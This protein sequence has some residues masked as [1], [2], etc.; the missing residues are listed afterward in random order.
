MTSD[1]IKHY[2]KNNFFPIIKADEPLIRSSIPVILKERN[3]AYSTEYLLPA[4]Q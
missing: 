1:E 4:L 2:V 3:Y